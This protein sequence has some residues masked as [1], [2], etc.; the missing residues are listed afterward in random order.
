VLPGAPVAVQ[1]AVLGH[2]A[3]SAAGAVRRGQ[4]GRRRGLRAHRPDVVLKLLPQLPGVQGV[5][6]EVLQELGAFTIT[7]SQV[8]G[9]FRLL[10]EEGA[11]PSGR[12]WNLVD[13]LRYTVEKP[14][15]P[16]RFIVMGD[17]AGVADRHGAPSG[18]RAVRQLLDGR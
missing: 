16:A 5:I 8:K 7:I 11:S 2:A 1:E 18:L 9:L 12:P 3:A 15:G 17:P 6:T 4:Q 10:R 14:S 13:V